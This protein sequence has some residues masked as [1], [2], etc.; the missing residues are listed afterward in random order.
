MI[1]CMNAKI[2]RFQSFTAK[3]L[4]QKVKELAADSRNIQFRA[5]HVKERM[6][7]RNLNMRQVL[8]CIRNGSHVGEPLKD[9][10]GDWR[11]KLRRLVAGRRIQ[12]VVAIKE[13]H[14]FV[15]TVI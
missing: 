13:D 9:E 8:E 12:V 11:I 7:G 2:I 4:E 10:L 6:E 1:G 14:V 3:L 5:F 15:V